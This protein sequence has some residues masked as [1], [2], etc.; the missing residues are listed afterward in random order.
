MIRQV[1][2]GKIADQPVVGKHL[3]VSWREY[4]SRGIA[5]LHG[6]CRCDEA[7]E[8]STIGRITTA[9]AAIG[10]LAIAILLLHA[11]LRPGS[12][13]LQ[14]QDFRAGRPQDLPCIVA[15]RGKV[16]AR[17]IGANAKK[18]QCPQADPIQHER[19]AIHGINI[20]QGRTAE[21]GSGNACRDATTGDDGQGREEQTK[22]R[23]HS[24][25]D[26]NDRPFSY[27]DRSLIFKYGRSHPR[28]SAWHRDVADACALRQS[29]GEW[30][31]HR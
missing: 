6:G 28:T 13:E 23:D 14:Y 19:L 20:R 26:F 16:E 3:Y 22:T 25:I 15:A 11:G 12:N 10:C 24:A 29:A 18:G 5:G 1:R 9:I 7:F 8:I 31:I 21:G 27:P 17:D 4:V 30:E 2:I